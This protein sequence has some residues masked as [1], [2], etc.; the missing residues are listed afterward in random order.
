M[1]IITTTII[2]TIIITTIIVTVIIII[3]LLSKVV[4]LGQSADFVVLVGRLL[5]HLRTEQ[6]DKKRT[7]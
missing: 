3:D 6:G 7:R 4:S 1:W 5:G 2:T